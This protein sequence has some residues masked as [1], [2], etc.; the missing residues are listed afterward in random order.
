MRTLERRVLKGAKPADTDVSDARPSYWSRFLNCQTRCTHQHA[1]RLEHPCLSSLSETFEVSGKIDG[2]SQHTKF[3]GCSI[4]SQARWILKSPELTSLLISTSAPSMQ[5]K[6]KEGMHM[7]PLLLMG[8]SHPIAIKHHETRA[9]ADQC[10]AHQLGGTTTKQSCLFLPQQGC[11]TA[12][13]R[14]SPRGAPPCRSTSYHLKILTFVWT[15]LKT[16]TKEVMLTTGDHNAFLTYWPLQVLCNSLWQIHT[17][18]LC[19]YCTC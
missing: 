4:S 17:F 11:I 6:K 15:Q 19:R 10:E 12:A 3:H 14:K 16:V 18:S 2:G 9:A 13:S 7:W 5:S 1:I 8:Q